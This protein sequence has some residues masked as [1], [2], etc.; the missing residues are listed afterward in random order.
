M[1]MQETG[2][3]RV[4]ISSP[5]VG[6]RPFFLTM[7]LYSLLFTVLIWKPVSLIAMMFPNEKN[8]MRVKPLLVSKEAAQRSGGLP[9]LIPFR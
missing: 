2:D 9:T 7:L 3:P 6:F 8:G 1:I 5:D 4:V